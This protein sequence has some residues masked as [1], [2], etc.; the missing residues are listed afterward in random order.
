MS[1]F[2]VMYSESQ[3]RRV[4]Y[5]DDKSWKHVRDLASKNKVSVSEALRLIIEGYR[6]AK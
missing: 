6:N 5:A 1:K 2:E 4:V 3:K